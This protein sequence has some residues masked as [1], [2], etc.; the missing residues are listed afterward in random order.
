MISTN[1]GVKIVFHSPPIF[2]PFVCF[3]RQTSRNRKALENQPRLIY[4]TGMNKEIKI[5]I[6]GQG[7]E[8]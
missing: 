5:S 6:P 8:D 1:I 7:N 4:N 2:H 3:T